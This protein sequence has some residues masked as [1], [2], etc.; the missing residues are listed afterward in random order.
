[1]RKLMI[2][3]AGAQGRIAA[4]TARACGR[5]VAGFA[6]DTMAV[7]TTIDGV[8]VR[9]TVEDGLSRAAADPDLEWCVA[10]GDCRARARIGAGLE[11][12]GGRLATLIHPGSYV[13]DTAS[14]GAGSFVNLAAAIFP[15][16]LV[17]TL[18]L[19]DNHASVG[20]DNVLGDAVFVGPGAHLGSRS[21]LGARA[22]VGMGAV[23]APSVTL[24]A[25]A[26]VG[27]GAAVHHD[28]PAGRVAVGNPAR[29]GLRS[30]R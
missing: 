26:M 5:E 29:I 25:D 22:F 10:I 4:A 1:M 16:A 15:G 20:I 14:L 11:A 3:G 2:V 23:I 9:L 27:A 21:T 24:G 7:G 13:S 30:A 8:T 19:V 6:D 17:G 28:V 12:A 18:G